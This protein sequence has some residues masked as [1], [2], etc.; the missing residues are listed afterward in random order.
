[1]P[2]IVL[3][4]GI[5]FSV[6]A[7]E[8]LPVVFVKV[9]MAVPVIVEPLKAPVKLMAGKLPPEKVRF[10]TVPDTGSV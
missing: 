3:S 4:T 5:Y 9:N 2:V 10:E 1:M 7:L 6:I 8:I